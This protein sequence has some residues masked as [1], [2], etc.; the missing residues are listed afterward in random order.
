M[1]P[2]GVEAGDQCGERHLR[3]RGFHWV[4]DSDIVIAASDAQFFDPHVSIGQVVAIEAIGL[5]RQM[6]AEAV[7]RMAFVG[8]YERMTP[9]AHT[10]WG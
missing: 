7:M 3:R 9:S 8:K 4:A 5:I 10:S 2:G 6:P 1:A